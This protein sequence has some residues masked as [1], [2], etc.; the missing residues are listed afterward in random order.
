MDVCL[1]N[2]PYT[3]IARPSA[4]LGLLQAVLER[5][6]LRAETLYADLLF[7][8][9]IGL[10]SYKLIIDTRAP[11]ALGDWTFTHIAFPNFKPDNEAY[12]KRLIERNKL[13]IN[14]S[15]QE[16]KEL[17]WAVRDAASRFIEDLAGRLLDLKPRVIGCTS[18]LVQ[19]VSS[20]SLFRR[21]HEL[22]PDIISVMGGANCETVMGQATHRLFPWV[23][24]V[25]AGEGDGVITPLVRAILDHGR[26]VASDALP[27]GIFAPTHRLKGYPTVSDT[28]SG[29]VPRAISTS[30]ADLP[31]PNYDNYFQT[32]N[33]SKAL[34][35]NVL[36]SIPIE[37]SRGC[38]WGQG[39]TNGCTFCSLNGCGMRFRS[40]PAEK[41]MDELDTLY[42]KY[43][44]HRFYAV[45]NCV[46]M[47]YF[48]TLFPELARSGKPYRL[49]YELMA[50]LKQHD[51]KVMREAGVT[52]I[53]CGIESLHDNILELV[54]K[55][56][57]A[58]QNVQFLKWCRQYGIFVGWNV[59]CDFP[60]E[61][62]AWYGEMAELLPLLTHLQPPRGF[63]RLR[64]DRFS[65]Y[66]DH[67]KEYGLDI[68]PSELA[69]Y[70]YPL[71]DK[72][73]REQTYFFEDETRTRQPLVSSLFTRPGIK[74]AAREIGRWKKAFW[75]GNLP[76]LA[77]SISDS[78]IHIRDTR[79]AAVGSSFDLQGVE[80]EIYLACE[81][82]RRR[83]SLYDQLK[84]EGHDRREVESA[85]HRLLDYKLMVELDGRLLALAVCE[86]LADIPKKIDY[87]GGEVLAWM[88]PSKSG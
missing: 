57:R 16:F 31:V 50:N 76:T 48:K 70:V 75:S 10:R 71:D 43:D 72:E 85:I 28:R 82:A 40:K 83:K 73:L 39:K 80:S 60:G 1:V 36:I 56:C 44:V 51:V 32:I 78:R 65:R 87:P 8:E 49:Y 52:W 30:I 59:M 68:H 29:D 64:L 18:T 46:D 88:L 33:E 84:K 69:H 63:V 58:Y 15:P 86:P 45:D 6:G 77:M 7:A 22:A 67:A 37:T 35:E 13:Y 9:Q 2:M 34:R 24:Y 25:V 27:E 20:L 55:G 61:K 21:I 3:G 42:R 53:W 38:W 11:D 41:V 14:C 62:D 81:K 66:H 47:C 74:A 17:L 19:H 26:E 23:D 79:P 12:V 5:D 4:A 54:N